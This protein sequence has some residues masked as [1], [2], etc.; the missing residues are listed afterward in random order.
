MKTTHVVASELFLVSLLAGCAN[1]PPDQACRAGLEYEYWVLDHNS[2]TL[3]GYRSPYFAF[4]LS[5]AEDTEINGDYESCLSI[6]KMARNQSYEPGG[7][8]RTRT[9]DSW[10]GLTYSYIQNHSNGGVVNDA[11]HHAAGHTHHHGHN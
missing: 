7:N 11:E 3:R 9:T 1:L 6:L 4:L 8:N 10:H 5:A 2:R